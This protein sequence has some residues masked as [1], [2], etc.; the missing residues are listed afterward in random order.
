[1]TDSI[2]S[3]LGPSAV[4]LETVFVFYSMS[5]GWK[6]L[7]PGCRSLKRLHHYSEMMARLDGFLPTSIKYLFYV[8]MPNSKTAQNSWLWF[9]SC[10]QSLYKIDI[11]TLIFTDKIDTEKCVCVCVSL[12]CLWLLRWQSW[13]LDPGLVGLCRVITITWAYLLKYRYL[14]PMLR[15]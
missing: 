11:I 9:I 5:F 12:M 6:K 8:T 2:F 7:L 3:L 14:D 10:A 1:M 13:D 15:F 4:S